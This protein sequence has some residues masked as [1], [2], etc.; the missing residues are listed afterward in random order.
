MGT[1]HDGVRPRR[2]CVRREV[3]VEAEVRAPRGVH[4]ERDVVGVGGRGEARDVPDRADVRGVADEDRDGVGCPRQG[5]GDVGGV[6]A[7]G[8]AVPGVHPGSDPHRLQAGEDQ[9]EEHRAVQGPGDHHPVPR[10]SDG[11]GEG[12]VAVGRATHREAAEV[13]PPRP[14]GPCLGVG[15][16]SA[17]EPHRVEPGVERDVT[18]HHVADEVEPVLV[19]GDRERR[20]RLLVEPQPG[21]EQ[22]RVRPET[23][24]VSRHGAPPTP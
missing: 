18:G 16:D 3:G 9:A 15:E 13:D 5:R 10:P 7:G 21:I 23:A 14:C 20:R 17:G 1:R 22:W 2:E 8:Q 12:L 19:A 11:E 4:D 6:Q 24:G